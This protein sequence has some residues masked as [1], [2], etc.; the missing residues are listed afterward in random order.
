MPIAINTNLNSLFA[1][2][3][4]TMNARLQTKTMQQLSTGQRI[5]SAGDDAAGLAISNR[6]TSQINGLNQATQNANDAISLL[7]TAEGAL[8][9]QTQMLQ[10]MRT[11]ALQASTD[12]TVST[13]K[14][15]LNTEYAQLLE[16]L[17]QIGANTQWNGSNILDASG[18]Q[19][20]TGTYVFQVGATSSVTISV[21]ISDMST[22]GALSDV[23]GSVITSASDAQTAID[24]IDLAIAAVDTQRTALGA[25][26]NRLTYTA[27]NLTNIA[28]QATQSRSR[29]L[30]TDFS[31]ASAT[32]ARTMIIQQA[33]TAMLAQANQQPQTVLAL[34][35]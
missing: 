16:Q 15:A 31:E 32:L 1:Q 27:D 23:S 19:A 11:L 34:L 6:M 18:G 2:D 14:T 7:Q 3:A 25:G 13:D 20:T 8:V 12:S 29:I 26:I 24:N 17:D 10:R 5:N 22:S 9:Q 35:K 30:D 28:Q 21:D 4:L 33:A